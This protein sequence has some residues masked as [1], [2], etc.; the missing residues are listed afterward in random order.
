VVDAMI[1]QGPDRVIIDGYNVSGLIAPDRFSTRA[2]R[3]DV[4]HRA[5]KLVRETDAAIV[6]VFDAQRSTEGTSTFTSAEGVE[7]V[8]EGDTTADDTIAAMAHANSD[9][10]I[11]IT[12]DREIHNRV[13]R[14]GCVS[15][16]SSAFVSWTEHLNRS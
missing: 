7:V 4:V 10:C 13:R 1:E 14:T 12:N 5:A 11:V 3:D 15:I 8:F 9:R 2:A 16:F 6:V